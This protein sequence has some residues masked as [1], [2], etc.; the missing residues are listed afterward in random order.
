MQG[1]IA[2]PAHGALPSPELLRDWMAR[3]ERADLL[4]E[5]QRL[6][7]LGHGDL[8]SFSPK[9][10]IPLTQLCRDTCG[11]CTFAHPPRKGERAFMTPEQVLAVARAGA[12]AGCTEALFTL[13]ERPEDRY[14]VAR[15]EL[16]EL[17]HA[18]TLD[19]LAAMAALVLRETGLLPH[20]NA[21]VMAEADLARLRR[22]GVSQGLML[23]GTAP[24]LLAKGGAHY[25]S[26]GKIPAVRLETIAA[27]GRQAIPFTSGILIGLGETRAERVEALL[28]L[29]ALHSEHGHIQEI[30][31]QNFQPKPGTRMADAAA[32]SMEELLWTAAAARLIFGPEMNIQ[33]P[34]NLSFDRFP[35]LLAAGINDWGGVSPVTPDHVNPEARWPDLDLL[36]RTTEAA[37]ATLVSRLPVYP[38]HVAALD[39]WVDPVLHAPVLRAADADGWGRADPWAPGKAGI[40]PRLPRLAPRA[41]PDLDAILHRAADGYRLNAAQIARLFRARG[42][43]VQAIATAADELRARANGDLVRYVVNRNINY[44]NICAYKCSFCAFSKGK[45][46]DHLRGRPYL[47]DLDEVSRRAAEAWDRGATEVCMQGGIHPSFTGRTY[48]DLIAAAKRGA[49]GIHVHAFSPLEV[50]HG[51]ET[52]GLSVSAYLER[53]R[54]AGLGSLPGTAAE[55]LT[56]RARALLCPDKLT[57]QGWLDVIEAAHGVGLPTTSTIMFGHIDGPDDW[58]AHLLAL[59]DLQERSGGITEFVPLP[60]VHME[61]PMYHRG[62]SR[63]GPTFRE[64]VLMH[65]VARLA[66]HPLIPNIQVSWCKLGAEGVLAALN[67][68]VNDVGGTLMNESISRAAG[69]EFGQELPPAQMD[70]L[71]ARAGR[72]GAQRSTLYGTVPPGQTAR[73]YAAEPLAPLVTGEIT[74]R[75]RRAA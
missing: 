75:A 64:V 60:F 49:P 44:T 19:Y 8:V 71:I 38:A 16:V 62:Q 59:R 66:L 33:V 57:V 73:S 47:V 53:L 65:A 41:T 18:T 56:D 23:E 4:Q 14:R 74:P 42:P 68:G 54:D 55:V 2:A 36:R 72:K 43:E 39:R 50:A 10:F 17:G 63:Q 35:E 5:A 3:L 40:V 48:L 67:A 69:T 7:R 34:P 13:G 22:V 51:A 61:A 12:A 6:K 58:A 28:A 29:E 27:A 1:L 31:V 21:G 70:A 15:E 9:V 25:G 32:P 37:G 46:A 26:K 52:L 45:T 24:V 11:Y 20:L 30:I